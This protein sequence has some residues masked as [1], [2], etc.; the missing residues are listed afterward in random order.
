MP[1]KP[2]AAHDVTMNMREAREFIASVP[3]RTVQMAEVGRHWKD[4]EHPWRW[5]IEGR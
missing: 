2:A 5:R 3:W 4:E 1:N